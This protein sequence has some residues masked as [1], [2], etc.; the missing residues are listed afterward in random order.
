MGIASQGFLLLFLPLSL[1]I[2]W[3]LLRRPR[4]KLL[5]LSL[6]SLLFYAIAGKEYLLLLLGLSAATYALARVRKFTLGILLNLLAL[7]F[8]KYGGFGLQ[9]AGLLAQAWGLQAALPLLNLALPLGISFYVFKHISYL[10]SVRRGRCPAASDPWLFFTY[11]AFFPSVSAGPLSGYPETASQL[12]ALPSRLEPANLYQGL[13]HISAGLAKK[14]L[15]ADILRDALG[16]GLFGSAATGEGLAWAWLSLLIYAFQLYFDF[17]G[18]TDLALGI[19]LLFGVTLPP[20]FNNPYLASNLAQFWQRWHISLSSW[21]RAYVFMPFS[22]WLLTHLGNRHKQL[23]MLLANLLTMTLIGVWHGTGWLFLLWGLY[24]GL[25]LSLRSLLAQRGVQI[26]GRFTGQALT[27][28]AVLIGWAIFLSPDLAFAGR[29]FSGL[30]GLQ[31]VGNL[32]PLLLVYDKFTLATL[33]IAMLL[34]ALGIVEALHLPPARRAWVAAAW[35][36][37]G[38]LCILMLGEEVEFLYVLF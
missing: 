16:A 18:Y 3:L 32:A 17:S 21:I 26:R 30:L 27:F 38:L 28:V 37:L 14:I 20:N 31:G 7:A 13:L 33:A 19:A 23:G 1:L 9:Q 10:V 25:L 29:L 22:G 15:I 11:A 2:Y 6:L 34:S 4:Q 35:G 8:F 36:L 24:H 5:F 12:Q